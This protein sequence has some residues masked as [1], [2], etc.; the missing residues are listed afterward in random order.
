MV[1]ISTD[2]VRYL[3]TLS[4]LALS[5]EEVEALRVDIAN[6][7]TYVHELEQLDTSD[8]TPTYQVTGLSNVWREDVIETGG[9][10]ARELVELA[11][12]HDDTSI[13]VP[14]VLDR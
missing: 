3:A 6:I 14:K 8:V 10:E 12:R 2:D 7:L 9:V 4:A 5:D 1:Q 11:P 13:Q